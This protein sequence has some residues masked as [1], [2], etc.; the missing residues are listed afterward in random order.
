MHHS[1]QRQ[2]TARAVEEGH[3]DMNDASR[4]HKAPSSPVGAFQPVQRRARREA[5]CQPGRAARAVRA[6]PAAHRG[7]ASRLCSHGTDPRRT[8]A[9]GGGTTGGRPPVLRHVSAFDAEQVINVPKIPQ[10]CIPHRAVFEP[11]LAEQLV[12][13]PTAVT[14]V[15][16]SA[17]FHD[18]HGHEWVRVP[19]PTGVCFWKVGTD[20]TQ[21]DPSGLM[22]RQPR[23]GM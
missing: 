5:A 13:V 8:S 2:K 18:R 19:G 21:W 17:L 1:A 16:G 14:H 12:Q 6:G 11:Q 7:A 20:H 10:D 9:A 23:G 4:R 22:H 15:P 3:E